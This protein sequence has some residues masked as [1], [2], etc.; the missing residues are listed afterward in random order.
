MVANT[1]FG[2]SFTS[3]LVQSVRAKHSLTYSINSGFTT[4]KHQGPFTISTFTKNETVGKTIEVI[5]QQ[6]QKIQEKGVNSDEINTQ[7][8]SKSE[9]LTQVD[10]LNQ[11]EILEVQPNVNLVENNRSISVKVNKNFELLFEGEGWIYLGDFSTNKPGSISFSDRIVGE[12]K[13]KFHFFA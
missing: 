6:I 10:F 13:T 9:D 4:L 11:E 2:G 7:G 3:R 5:F 8:A 1:I 12:G